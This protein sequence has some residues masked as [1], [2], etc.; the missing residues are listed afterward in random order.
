MAGPAAVGAAVRGRAGGVVTFPAAAIV[1]VVVG[2]SSQQLRK[3]GGPG[4]QSWEEDGAGDRP[5][6]PL[7]PVVAG[8]REW[9]GA[10]AADARRV[11]VTRG[12]DLRVIGRAP[13][14]HD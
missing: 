4:A 5:R 7:Q 10:G 6:G 8:V 2:G 14:L 1:I 11:L 9:A 3:A 12:W 13:S